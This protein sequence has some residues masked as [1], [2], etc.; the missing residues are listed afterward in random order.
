MGHAYIATN[1]FTPPLARST[2]F[3]I[4]RALILW[5][6]FLFHLYEVGGTDCKHFTLLSN[7]VAILSQVVRFHYLRHDMGEDFN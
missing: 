2:Q 1:I 6:N 5:M 3:M 7:L 4:H